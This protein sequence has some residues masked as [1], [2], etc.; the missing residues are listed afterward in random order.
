VERPKNRGSSHGPPIKKKKKDKDTQWKGLRIKKV[1]TVLL[2][3]KRNKD[4]DTQWKGLRIEEVVT[5]LLL[6]KRKKI[7]I[8]SG[9]A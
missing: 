3:K 8:H 4:K 9:K 1:V 6:K 2:L 5:V 7:K